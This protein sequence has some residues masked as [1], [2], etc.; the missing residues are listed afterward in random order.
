MQFSAKRFCNFPD[1]HD[2]EYLR[3]PAGLNSGVLGLEVIA[4]AGGTKVRLYGVDMHGAHF[5]GKYENGLRNTSDDR[6]LAFHRQYADWAASHPNIEV[7]NC[8]PGSALKCFPF[9]GNENER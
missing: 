3:I 2:I 7:L 8:T 6:R 5:F 4:R 1:L 9:E